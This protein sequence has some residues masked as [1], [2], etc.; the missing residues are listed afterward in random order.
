[1]ED[2]NLIKQ[3][4]AEGQL[5]SLVLSLKVCPVCNSLTRIEAEHCGMCN[6]RGHFD[7][8]V[9]HVSHSLAELLEKCPELLETLAPSSAPSFLTRLKEVL[10]REIR[11]RKRLDLSA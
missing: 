8:E 2:F 6:W 11:L 7:M 4:R 1:M 9:D 10:S 5:Q 3:T